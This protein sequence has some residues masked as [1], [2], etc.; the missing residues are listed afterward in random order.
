MSP[1]SY[2]R[3]EGVDDVYFVGEAIRSIGWELKSKKYGGDPFLQESKSVEQLL[4]NIEEDLRGPAP[5]VAWLLDADFATSGGGIASRWQSVRH[6][7]VEGLKALK[8]DPKIV[9]TALPPDGLVLDFDHATTTRRC[10]VFIWPN[11]IADGMLETVLKQAA[12]GQLK[13]LEFAGESAL[14]ART[15]HGATF[16]QCHDDKAHWRTLMAWQE[17]PGQ[18]YGVAVARGHV[19]LTHADVK[20]FLDWFKLMFEVQPTP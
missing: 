19:D 6:H 11:N 17:N 16:H 9:P 2:L 18:G 20:R 13:L 4:K 7:L 8:V 12:K 1:Q 15:D 14:A 5:R 10:G 3:V